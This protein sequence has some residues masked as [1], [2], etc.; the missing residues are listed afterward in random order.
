M[1]VTQIDAE[2]QH[3][4]ASR[5]RAWTL[6][7]IIA[8]IDL[9]PYA[10]VLLVA[11]NQTRWR[12]DIMSLAMCG[13]QCWLAALTGAV[14][15]RTMQWRMTLTGTF[16]LVLVPVVFTYVVEWLG[17]FLN[18]APNPLLMLVPLMLGYAIM[19]LPACAAHAIVAFH[20]QSKSVGHCPVCDYN[21]TG[22]VSGRC[23]ECG[24]IFSKDAV[25]KPQPDAIV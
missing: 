3:I 10:F 15:G 21:L 14:G 11:P 18:V 9:L 22:N 16:F 19:L 12:D 6:F 8:V 23:P 17:S 13:W 1:R 4:A 24:T 2:S 7:F 5:Q 25:D 20:R